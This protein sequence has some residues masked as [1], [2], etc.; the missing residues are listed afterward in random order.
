MQQQHSQSIVQRHFEKNCKLIS[1]LQFRVK[2]QIANIYSHQ[3]N[4]EPLALKLD[5]PF[6]LSFLKRN[7]SKISSFLSIVL[8]KQSIF[9][10]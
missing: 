4:K 6:L 8:E 2:E 7:E 10:T 1:R 5:S 9:I 3:L